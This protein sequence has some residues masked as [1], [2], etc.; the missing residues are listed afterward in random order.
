MK[1]MI[2]NS[3]TKQKPKTILGRIRNL[4]LDFILY[5]YTAYILIY[6]KYNYCIYYMRKYHIH[7]TCAQGK[8][9]N[10]LCITCGI[11]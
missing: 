6:M 2:E 5:L 1:I 4:V 3:K 10:T 11:K 8:T 7:V 9:L